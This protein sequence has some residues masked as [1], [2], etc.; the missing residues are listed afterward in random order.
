[1]AM[2]RIIPIRIA[3]FAICLG[4]LGLLQACGTDHYKPLEY[5]WRIPS[6]EVT[7]E[8]NAD[9]TFVLSERNTPIKGTWKLSDDN[10]SIIFK[11]PGKHEKALQIKLISKTKLTLSDNG[12]DQEYIRE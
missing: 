7:L 2:L 4:C 11:E 3:F 10:K 1:M 9:S 6:D 8:L 5:K 12:L